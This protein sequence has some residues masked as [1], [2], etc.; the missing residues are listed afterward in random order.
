MIA[1]G[2]TDPREAAVGTVF[3]C[4]HGHANEFL[5][6]ESAKSIG[7][8][9]L[10]GLKP[11]AGCSMPKRYRKPITIIAVRITRSGEAGNSFR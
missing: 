6:R 2:S 1:T 11:C 9:L 10:D 3:H 5:S 8:E 4:V 7:V